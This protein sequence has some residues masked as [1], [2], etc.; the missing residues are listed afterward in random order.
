MNIW[1]SFIIV[2]LVGYILGSISFA[3]IISKFYGINILKAGSGSPGATN[4]KRVVGKTA[5]NLVFLLDCLKGVIATAWPLIFLNQTE[6]LSFYL[7]LTG[8]IA[9]VLGH[10]FSIFLKFQGGKGIAT[11][12]GGILILMPWSLLIGLI[13]WL[14]IFYST[15]YVSLAS[16]L[17]GLSLPMSAIFIHTSNAKIILSLILA[18]LILIRHQPN[19]KRLL[20][21]TEN[22]FTKTT[23]EE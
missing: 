10:N 12:M 13:I 8:L 6:N 18:I 23:K 16:I 11:T 17:F 21:G 3:V 2:A 9:A 7:S 20:N 5:G 15:R 19:I 14:I 4:V 1:T 22:R